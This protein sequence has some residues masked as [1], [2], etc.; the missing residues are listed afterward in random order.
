MR[1]L[2]SRTQLHGNLQVI[3]GVIATMKIHIHI[4]HVLTNESN[5]GPNMSAKSLLTQ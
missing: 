2:S 4:S 5:S 1:V 3:H